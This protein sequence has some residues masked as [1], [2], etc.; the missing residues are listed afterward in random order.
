MIIEALTFFV[1]S[2]AILIGTCWLFRDRTGSLDLSAGVGRRAEI[3]HQLYLTGDPRGI[4]GSYLPS[5]EFL[6]E[7]DTKLIECCGK[8]GCLGTFDS[9]ELVPW[10]GNDCHSHV[11][12]SGNIYTSTAILLEYQTLS[13]KPTVVTNAVN[14]THTQVHPPHR[15]TGSFVVFNKAPGEI[16]TPVCS[17]SQL[18]ALVESGNLTPLRGGS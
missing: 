1:G 9:G 13:G 7:A 17:N 11:R 3:E 8:P 15:V 12:G 16:V 10:S 4:Y 6:S 5:K 14:V 18:A 2:T